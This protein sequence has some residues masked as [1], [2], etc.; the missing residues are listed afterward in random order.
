M[1]TD[2]ELYIQA[3]ID[4]EGELLS[5]LNRDT[6]VKLVRSR[7]LSGH[8]QG[9]MLK[10]FCRM[11][12]AKKVLELGTFT[13]YSAQ[14]FAEALPDDGIIYTIEEN[15]ELEDFINEYLV[16]SPN[17]DKIHLLMGDAK[18]II[19]TLDEE[20]DMVFIDADKRE[21]CEYYELVYP[22]VRKGGFM[23]AD[24][25]LWSGKILDESEHDPQTEGL[26]RFNDMVAADERVEKVF[27]P[28]RDGLTI[29]YKK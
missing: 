28:S 10:M 26:R 3:H 20:F 18:A 9:R 13:G 22:K 23:L 21:Y 1:F 16:Q 17:K 25:T 4:P 24:N 29:I 27:V 15:D 7:M 19:P 11:I 12:N 8:V 5:R 6:N 14:C 2:E